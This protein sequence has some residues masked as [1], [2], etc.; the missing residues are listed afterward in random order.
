MPTT[1]LNNTQRKAVRKY[2]SRRHQLKEKIPFAKLIQL[3]L[4]RGIALQDLKKLLK[5]EELCMQDEE[6][7]KK[8]MKMNQLQIQE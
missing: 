7:R 6:R 2:L 3:Q 5:N 1:H 8:V 4:F